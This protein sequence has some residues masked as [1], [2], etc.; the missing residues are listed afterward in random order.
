MSCCCWVTYCCGPATPLPWTPTDTRAVLTVY[1]LGIDGHRVSLN[2]FDKNRVACCCPPS[3]P[4]V[5][6]LDVPSQL[7][8]ALSDDE[9]GAIMSDTHDAVAKRAASC[10][11]LC[12]MLVPILGWHCTLLPYLI[13]GVHSMVRDLQ[14][15]V[16]D[17]HRAALFAKGVS[18]GAGSMT[19]YDSNCLYVAIEAVGAPAEVVTAVQP[20]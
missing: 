7:R 2:K 19:Q 3:S 10:P 17:K 18:I 4:P 1:P 20:R 16:V 11:L 6:Q 9:F 8:G 13:C 15:D 12:F 5:G 14:S